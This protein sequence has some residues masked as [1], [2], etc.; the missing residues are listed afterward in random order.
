MTVASWSNENKWRV[1]EIYLK[2]DCIFPCSHKAMQEWRTLSN[3]GWSTAVLVLIY[4]CKLTDIAI[5]SAIWDLVKEED[6][7]LLMVIYIVPQC[8]GM[9]LE[10]QYIV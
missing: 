3:D 8:F 4:M 6:I 2:R 7:C 10:L 5:L 9:F 1:V